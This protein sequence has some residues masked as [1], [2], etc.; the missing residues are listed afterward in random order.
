MQNKP[1]LN[2]EYWDTRWENA[3]TKWDIGY[4]SP[5]IT[6]YID[7][8]QSKDLAIL[9]PGCGNAYEAEYLVQAG[10]TNITLIDIAP[11][12]V[13]NLRVKFLENKHIKIICTDFFKHLGTY[14]I[15]FE[16][17]FLSA[18]NPLSR[19]KY[20][21]KM[22]EL[23]KSE[24]KLVGVLFGIEFNNP[25]PPYGGTISEYVKLFEPYFQ[26]NKLEACYN[27]IPPRLGSEVFIN[28]VKK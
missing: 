27:S 9:I 6:N 12:A 23:L 22:A 7:T 5:V 11:K 1:S 24:G 13:N 21:Q 2:Q 14:D 20:V 10:F 17:T 28:L 25:N 15:I 19:V 4:P 18:L 26:I 8:L 16:Q 3:E